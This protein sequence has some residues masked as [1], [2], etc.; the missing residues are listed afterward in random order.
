MEIKHIE[1]A[2]DVTRVALK[3]RLDTLGVDAIEARFNAA[4][5]P[6][7]KHSIVDLSEVEFLSSLG[8]RMLLTAAKALK[9]KG[10]RLVLV[11]ARPLVGEALRHSAID[12][13]I[14]VA[15]D[16]SAAAALLRG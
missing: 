5:V 8:V 4:L 1:H 7:G 2:D 15:A 10:A 13:L 9:R 14:P 6:R 3:G 11:G 16:S 12:Q